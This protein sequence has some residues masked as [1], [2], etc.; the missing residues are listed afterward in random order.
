MLR[1]GVVLPWSYEISKLQPSFDVEGGI[2]TWI[3]NFHF[4]H[5]TSALS[6]GTDVAKDSFRRQFTPPF[7]AS[8]NEPFRLRPTNH[9]LSRRDSLQT[10]FSRTIQHPLS[11]SRHNG[12]YALYG[13]DA[14]SLNF[15]RFIQVCG[16]NDRLHP[17]GALGSCADCQRRR[18][19]AAVRGEGVAA[20]IPTDARSGAGA[21][22]EVWAVD[23]MKVLYNNPSVLF[24]QSI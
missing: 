16:W 20:W 11:Q 5:H 10:L 8:S 15:G 13:A 7:L 23:G 12:P 22:H 3:P 9:P 18:A 24:R 6:P 2:R 21:R 4:A 17:R 14:W 1:E 19:T